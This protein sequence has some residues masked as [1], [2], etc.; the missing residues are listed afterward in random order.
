MATSQNFEILKSPI[1]TKVLVVLLTANHV[2][3]RSTTE[4]CAHES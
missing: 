1:L 3:E 4:F 2:Q